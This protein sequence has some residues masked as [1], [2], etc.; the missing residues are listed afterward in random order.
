MNSATGGS[1][2]PCLEIAVYAIVKPIFTLIT[3]TGLKIFF[4][5]QQEDFRCFMG[6]AALPHLERADQFANWS[7]CSNAADSFCW[8]S[9]LERPLLLV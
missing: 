9:V 5:F 7:D 6:S 3:H 8:W 1:V 2:Q 4:A